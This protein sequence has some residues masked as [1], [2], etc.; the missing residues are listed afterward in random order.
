MIKKRTAIFRYFLTNQNTHISKFSNL[1]PFFVKKKFN[2]RNELIQKIQEKRK[3][4][5]F[6]RKN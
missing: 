3:T 1:N 4:Q 6:F 5:L 2:V